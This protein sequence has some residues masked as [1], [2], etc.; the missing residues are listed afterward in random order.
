MTVTQIIRASWRGRK[1]KA[2]A[3]AASA[4][5]E[6]VIPFTCEC[7][8]KA[9]VFLGAKSELAE[10]ICSKCGKLNEVKR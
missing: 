6:K 10:V 3:P 9:D 4:P 1:P 8:A 2:I 7:G 5:P